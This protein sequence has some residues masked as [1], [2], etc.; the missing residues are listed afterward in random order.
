MTKEFGLR[1]RKKAMLKLNIVETLIKELEN[2]DY[3]AIKVKDI[4]AVVNTSEVTFFKYFEKKDELLQYYMLIWNYRRELRIAKSGRL[5]GL[6]GIRGIFEDIAATKNVVTILNTLLTFIARSKVK[7]KVLSLTDCEKWLIDDST[8]DIDV[9]DLS[10]QFTLHL[11]EAQAKG[12]LEPTA[13]LT[14]LQLLL[15]SLFYGGTIISHTT[16]IDLLEHYAH[17]ME[18]IFN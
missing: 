2:K 18:I 1:E 15:S 12:E 9:L 4:C 6:S 7:P 14:D 3:D 13:N 16:G 8:T 5:E 10:A 17:S 11:K